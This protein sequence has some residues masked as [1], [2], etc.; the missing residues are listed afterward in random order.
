MGVAL[1]TDTGAVVR[2]RSASE[3]TDGSIVGPGG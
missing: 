3:K 2:E 1:A